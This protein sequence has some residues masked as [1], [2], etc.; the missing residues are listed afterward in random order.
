MWC[1][2]R[3]KNASP[4]NLSISRHKSSP[5]N[6]SNWL[7]TLQIMLFQIRITS[8]DSIMTVI[9][10]SRKVCKVSKW[11]ANRTHTTTNCTSSWEVISTKISSTNQVEVELC[12]A[13][14][15]FSPQRTTIL[16]TSTS[17]T[18]SGSIRGLC[19]KIRVWVPRGVSICSFQVEEGLRLGLELGLGLE[20]KDCQLHEPELETDGVGTCRWQ[21]WRTS[22]VREQI[23]A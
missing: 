19:R 6:L 7:I 2:L 3:L 10:F 8:S 11:I 18:V 17:L 15:F 4:T 22:R 12:W 14:I 1:N 23:L 9:K 16:T 13:Q 20:S 21:A 5:N